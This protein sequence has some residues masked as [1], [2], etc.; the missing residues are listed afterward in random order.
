MAALLLLA[1][2]CA[3]PAEPPGQGGETDHRSAPPA[4][5]PPG[6]NLVAVGDVMLD[7]LTTERL[8]HYD[9]DYPFARIAS[10]LKEGDL[11]FANLE[12]PISE[13]GTAAQ[14]PY[15]FRAH[16]FTVEALTDSGINLVSLANNHI[17]DYGVDAL[18][19]TLELLEE[20]GIAYTGAGRNEAEARKGVTLEL[21]GVKT[22]VLAY[23]GVFRHGYPEWR[24]GPENPGTLYY[25]EREQFITDIEKARCRADVVIV[26][27]HFGEEYSHQVTDEQRETSRL[28]VDSGADLVLGHHSHTPQGIELYRGRPIVYSLGNFL[29]YPFSKSICNETYVLQTRVGQKGIESLRLIPVLLGNSQPY[30]AAGEEAARLRTLLT[31]LLEDLGT[32]WEIEGEAIVI[33]LP[34]KA[35]N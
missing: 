17:L 35:H 15:T 28:A 12:C 8:R 25:C 7:C 5:P 20:Q 16:P 2:S 33:P 10:T 21:G 11:T 19:D 4:P 30:P 31:G 26:S 24:A 27:L 22:T 6:F 29:F 14:K 9:P 1:I 23:S 34:E 32:A 18:E 3:A 13:R